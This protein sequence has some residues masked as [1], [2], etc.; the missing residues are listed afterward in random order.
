MS[1]EEFARRVVL[2][3]REVQRLADQG[4]L[5]GQKVGGEWRFHPAQV[6]EW[7]QQEMPSLDEERLAAIERVMSAAEGSEVDP[8][9]LLVT[10][11][12]GPLGIELA[13]PAKTRASVLRELVVVA[14]RT[15]LLYD[16]DGLHAALVAREDLC[17]T[18]LPNGVAVPHPKSPMPYVSAE[19]FLCIARVPGG[20]AFGGN[21][22]VLT[23]VFFLICC[24]EDRHHLYV[25][26][27][28]MRILDRA[29]VA[30]LHELASP[31]EVLELLVTRE[32]EV[33]AASS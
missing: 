12:I 31:E 17:P 24:H 6:T 4:K 8:D 9:G 14:E 5:P 23:R 2:D 7:L 26:A 1:L 13:L 3:V 20:I 25:L 11:L 19:P 30:A 16:A 33:H 27:R 28:L 21:G 15:G 18:A 10:S 29:T 32:R 22:K